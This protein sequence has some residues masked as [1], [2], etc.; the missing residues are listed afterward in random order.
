MAERRGADRRARAF[1]HL[2]ALFERDR[3]VVGEKPDQLFANT[4][5][6]FFRGSK[7]SLLNKLF[8]KLASNDHSLVL[9]TQNFIFGVRIHC[10]REICR[11]CPWR[12]CPDRDADRF[13]S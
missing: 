12:G 6:R 7:T 5:S 1:R 4:E 2:R 10:D 8:A 9:I 13:V 3:R 11:Q